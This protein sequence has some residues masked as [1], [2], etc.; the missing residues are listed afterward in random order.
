MHWTTK[1]CVGPVPTY[2][3]AVQVA[4]R[5]QQLRIF[6][7]LQKRFW[8]SRGCKFLGEFYRQN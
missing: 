4:I 6:G 7:L 2:Y 3:A 5:V 8:R 1:K